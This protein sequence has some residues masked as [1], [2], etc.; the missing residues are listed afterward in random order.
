MRIIHVLGKCGRCDQCYSIIDGSPCPHC[1]YNLLGAWIH[2]FGEPSDREA[3][4]L[5]YGKGKARPKRKG[6]LAIWEDRRFGPNGL[7]R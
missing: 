1:G 6:M 4:L 7:A 3:A 2:G 5:A